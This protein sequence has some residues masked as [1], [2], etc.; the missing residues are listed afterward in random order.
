MPE[1]FPQ[2]VIYKRSPL[3][4]RHLDDTR[5]YTDNDYALEQLRE[6]INLEANGFVNTE[7]KSEQACHCYWFGEFGRK[8]EFCIKSF[9]CTQP[10]NS[11]VILWLDIDNGFQGYERNPHI[12]TLIKHLEVK[13]YDP[14]R[15]TEGTP[16]ADHLH[17]ARFSEGYMELVKRG[18]AFRF[19]ILYKYG[20]TYFDLDIMF[21]QD[22]SPLIHTEFCYAWEKQ[23]Y[24][25]S[26]IFHLEAR[27]TIAT[28]LMQK[29]IKKQQVSPWY[30]FHYE[31]E[32]LKDLYV[33]PCA[34][35]D[36]IWQGVTID[37]A[38]LDYFPDFFRKFDHQFS[39]KLNIQSY[40]DFFPGAYA[41]HWHNEWNT[42]EHEDSL[43]GIF[44]KEFNRL[45]T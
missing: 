37:H 45:L 27:S 1:S 23:P 14:R 2:P 6:G 44:E 28:Y 8:Q 40:K 7:Y 5:L 24:A 29:C 19:L 11:K 12:Q 30:L 22:I 42:P 26:A 41:Y 16:W 33:L 34:F 21:L 32:E 31:D 15:E 25:N 35:F 17:L 13:A 18:D 10:V 20:G 3:N 36:P 4:W 43:F 9:L 38:P 39:N